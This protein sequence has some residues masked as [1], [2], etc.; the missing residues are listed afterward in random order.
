MMKYTPE[1]VMEYAREEDVKFIRMAFCDVYGRQRNVAVMADELPRAFEHGIAID[2][3]AIDGFNGSEVRS[4]LF[5]RPDPSTLVALPWRPQHGRV[6]QMFCD[7]VQPDGSPFAADTRRVLKEAEAEAERRGFVFFFGT[8][9]E[10]YL[11]RL[12]EDGAPTKTPYDSAGYMDVA[13]EDKGENVR[14]EICLTLEQMG[15][16]PESS[17]HE[18]GPGQNEIDF[19]YAQPLRAADNAMIFRS[20]VRAVAAQNGLWA[21]F[22][23]RPLPEHD[24]S[25][26][27]V[28]LSVRRDGAELPP[29]RLVPGL[30]EHIREMTLFL[31]PTENSYDR[32][33]RDKA[34][35]WVTWSEQNRSQLVRIP[36]AAEP[37][38]RAE[39]RSPD[40]ASNPYLAFALMIRA[41]L[42]GIERALP[43]PEPSDFNT[44]SASPERL[45]GLRKLP[46]SRAEAATAARESAFVRACLPDA[47]V[48][49]YCE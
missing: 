38:R 32:L 12:D 46:A 37:F 15:V 43:L 21:D 10:F 24:G 2:A 3:S 44:F 14:R 48:R 19:R 1:E 18:S 16:R 40:A 26:M 31:N 13:P 45:A 11:F 34:P 35:A 23:P 28:N 30:M 4:D 7:I 6:T 22:S 29:L 47:V 42:D 36:A 27:H 20:V 9:M 49:A 39:L 17:H 5:L 8:E 25:G 41:C 33:G